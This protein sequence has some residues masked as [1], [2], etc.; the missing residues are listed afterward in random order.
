MAGRGPPGRASEKP[1]GTMPTIRVPR[2]RAVVKAWLGRLVQWR[3]R[4][5]GLDLSELTFLPDAARL[6]LLRNGTDPVPELAELRGR[7]PVQKLDMPFGFSV[8]LV[9]GYEQARTVL[10]DGSSYSNDMQH[11]F[12]D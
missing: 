9:T 1:R 5:K 7:C 4:R 2:P 12:R 11:L 3:I 6:P 10:A 8:H